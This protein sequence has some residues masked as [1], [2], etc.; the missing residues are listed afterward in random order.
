MIRV[1]TFTF[2]DPA[3]PF[4]AGAMC[5]EERVRPGSGQPHFVMLPATKLGGGEEECRAALQRF[6]DDRIA[7]EQAKR[8]RGRMLNQR[9]AAQSGPIPA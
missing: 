5:F 6:L 8:A 7:A 3:A 4:R 2:S 1:F 9:R